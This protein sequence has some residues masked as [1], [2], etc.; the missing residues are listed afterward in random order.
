MSW[1]L[2]NF[3]DFNHK[4]A[5]IH[6][7]SN[8]TYKQLFDNIESIRNNIIKGKI[9]PGEVI[10]ILDDYSF[11]SISLLLALFQNKNIKQYIIILTGIEIEFR[12]IIE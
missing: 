10:S 2:E 12:N 5:I 4:I 1:I 8:Y 6:K 3:K 9:Q 11:N 7:D